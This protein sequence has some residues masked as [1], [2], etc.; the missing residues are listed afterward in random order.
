MKPEVKPLWGCLLSCDQQRDNDYT[1]GNRR[2]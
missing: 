2:L 1:I